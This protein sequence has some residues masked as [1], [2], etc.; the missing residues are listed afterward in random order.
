MAQDVDMND[1]IFISR[2]GHESNKQEN[3]VPED[4]A[5]QFFLEMAR[6]DLV[7]YILSPE[8]VHLVN[9]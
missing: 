9:S 8:E 5:Y 7:Y 6:N 2:T 3:L 1:S 4:H